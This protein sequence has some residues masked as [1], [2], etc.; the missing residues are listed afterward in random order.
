MFFKG[1]HF[2]FLEQKQACQ[3]IFWRI[4]LNVRLK[5]LEFIAKT[6]RHAHDPIKFVDECAVLNSI[7]AFFLSSKVLL[8]V[9]NMHDL[10]LAN[11][12]CIIDERVPFALF[13]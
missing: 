10:L 7:V 8:V 12:T 11:F 1:M 9:P 6:L 2:V 3:P 13:A 5:N 4:T